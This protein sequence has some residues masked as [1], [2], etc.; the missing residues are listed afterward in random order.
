M[1][2]AYFDP[3]DLKISG[4]SP[5]EVAVEATDLLRLVYR[6]R[7]YDPGLWTDGFVAYLEKK[8]KTREFLPFFALFRNKVIASSFLEIQG[9]R[10]ELAKSVIHEDYRQT[11]V[12]KKLMR[13][14]LPYAKNNLNSELAYIRIRAVNPAA[15]AIALEQKFVPVGLWFENPVRNAAGKISCREPI[16]F[17]EYYLSRVYEPAEIFTI[18]EGLPWINY[19]RSLIGKLPVYTSLSEMEV[20]YYFDSTSGIHYFANRLPDRRFRY[21]AKEEV[22]LLFDISRDTLDLQKEALNRGFKVT[23]YF[24]PT[25]KRPPEIVFTGGKSPVIP[26]VLPVGNH[27]FLAG[28]FLRLTDHRTVINK[29]S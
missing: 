8:I 14:R 20:G 25:D 15:V 21:H 22:A 23:G 11:G 12:G 13:M 6:E 10:V 27:D 16:L 28:S 5:R 26:A 1:K 9:D 24:P 3:D 29:N 19:V 17:A 2:I 4:L 7:Y 18:D